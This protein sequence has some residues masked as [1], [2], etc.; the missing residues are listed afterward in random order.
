MKRF[1]LLATLT[2]LVLS[3]TTTLAKPSASGYRPT[4]YKPTGGTIASM[5]PTNTQPVGQPVSPIRT[6]I[7]QDPVK[8]QPILHPVSPIQTII[9]QNPGKYLPILNPP[10]GHGPIN[11]IP[12]VFVDPGPHR[13]VCLPPIC[14]PHCRPYHEWCFNF[15]CGLPSL[16]CG[17]YCDYLVPTYAYP[18]V[19]W[20]RW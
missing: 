14:P 17:G 1:I 11:G 9:G 7:G 12:P 20:F 8:Y 5:P 15:C 13:P 6:V 18:P 3:A 19:C 10:S 16:F 2:T 4:N